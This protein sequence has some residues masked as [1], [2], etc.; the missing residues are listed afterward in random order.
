MEDGS[1]LPL[2]GVLI[3]LLLLWLNGIFYGFAAAVHNLSENEV[4]K[5]AQEGDKK[6]VRLL[7]LMNRPALYV[8][9]IP[10]IVMASGVCFG[11]FL[12]PWA[13][14]AFHPYI[15][16]VPALILVLA[17]GVVL[18]AALGILTFRRIGTYHSEKYAYRYLGAVSF[19]T[20]I[21]Y[22]LTVFI[23]LIAKLAARPFGV[24]LNQTEDA[25][26]E[27]EIISIVGEA[28]E[29]GVIEEN[30]A[31]MIQ[32]IISFNETEAKDVMTHRK[33]V[34]AF[35]QEDMLQEVI[36][37]MLEEGNSRYPVYIEKLD[38]IVGVIHYKD[39]LKFITKNSWA[40][41]KPLR[42]L[43][44][45][46][47]DA[48]FIP[49]TRGIGDLFRSMQAKKLHMAIVVDEYGQTAGIVSL[50]DILEEIVGDILD[51]YD[52]DEITFRTQIDNSVIIDGLAYLEDVAEEL[53]V[54]FG[55]VEFE[56][57]NGY[58]TSCLG[59]IPT[60]KD[61][62]KEI[63]ANGYRFKILSLGNKTIGKVRAE[64]IKKETKGEEK[65]QDIQNSQT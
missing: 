8:N 20:N 58:L 13:A 15:K 40:K 31:E 63:V 19:F 43:P 25:V 18:L 34:V 51:E 17:L 55:K 30:E 11:A 61:M 4:E 2:W 42:E 21:L 44:G 36:D 14:N 45:L 50:E 3:L 22:P 10:L 26:T 1:S 57:L 23:T 38:N 33:N 32:N 62:D 35:D 29:Q 49:E 52:E 60:E 48:A 12:V 64:K 54:D 7:E 9:A 46:I 39:A 65:C 5:R 47:R 59:H 28:H 6:S 56:T 24:D 27:E 16:H 53:E 41:F 37:V